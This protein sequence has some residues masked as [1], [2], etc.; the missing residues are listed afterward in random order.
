MM[1]QM[2]QRFGRSGN[3]AAPEKKEGKKEVALEGTVESE[4]KL[5]SGDAAGLLRES[6]KIRDAVTAAIPKKGAGEKGSEEDEEAALMQSAQMEQGAMQAG[7]PA[8]IFAGSVDKAKLAQARQSAYA[9]ARENAQE[10]AE[11]AGGKLGALMMV[12]SSTNTG[13]GRFGEFNGMDYYTQQYMR[14]T[15][16]VFDENSEETEAVSPALKE[17]SFS[18]AITAS[19]ALEGAK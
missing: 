3:A 18:V 1:Q 15:M 4:W 16:G 8:F 6:E 10:T 9:K 13:G 14:Q 7:Q 12:N 19:F 5:T 17:L 11:A 2:Q